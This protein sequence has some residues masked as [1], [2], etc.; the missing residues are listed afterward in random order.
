MGTFAF[1]I[2]SLAVSFNPIDRMA[3]G[4]GPTQIR[5][6]SSTACAKSGSSDKNP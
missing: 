5:P 3:E 2:N 1:C 4:D 6:A